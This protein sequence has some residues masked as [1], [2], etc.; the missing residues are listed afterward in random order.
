MA[1]APGAAARERELYEDA[2]EGY[3]PHARRAV[4]CATTPD[5]AVRIELGERRGGWAPP[6]DRVRLELHGVPGAGAA[7]VRVDGAEA[8]SRRSEDGA[9]VIELPE[10]PAATVVV[11]EPAPA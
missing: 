4:R 10:T 5:G 7:V 6:R 11:V 9:L 8:A 3:G 2:G 1:C